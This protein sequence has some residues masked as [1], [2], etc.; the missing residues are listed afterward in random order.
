MHPFQW[1]IHTFVLTHWGRV[2]HIWV[3]KLTIICSDNG[4]IWTPAGISTIRSLGTNFNE[5]IS[6]IHAFALTNKN[7]KMS[8]TGLQQFYLGPNVLI[9]L[10]FGIP[11]SEPGLL[12]VNP[13]FPGSSIS[14]CSWVVCEIRDSSDERT[15]A[16]NIC[17]YSYLLDK[18]RTN[19]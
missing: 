19:C 6:Q 11:P 5:I 17:H 12:F 2:T 4:I 1:N 15:R 9:R 8:S 3:T 14:I 7:F 18:W 13:H 10:G 16:L